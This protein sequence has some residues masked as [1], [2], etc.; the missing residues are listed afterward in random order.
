MINKETNTVVRTPEPSEA[1]ELE[2]MYVLA[3][4]LY[5]ASNDNLVNQDRY[6][7]LSKYFN[8]IP[9]VGEYFRMLSKQ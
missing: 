6:I 8:T 4:W 3:D 1:G 5:W 9:S 7:E 2:S